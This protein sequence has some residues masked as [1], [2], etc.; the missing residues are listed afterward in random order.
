MQICLLW[1]R[2]DLHVS[3]TKH[4]LFTLNLHLYFKHDTARCNLRS[5]YFIVNLLQISYAFKKL[6]VQSIILEIRH[7]MGLIGEYIF[8]K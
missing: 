5:G 2:C 1:K 4:I 3:Y 7:I 8:L 6:L